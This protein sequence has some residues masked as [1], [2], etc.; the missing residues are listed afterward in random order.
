MLQLD[1]MIMHSYVLLV[2]A[3]LVL[4]ATS[5]HDRNT[6]LLTVRMDATGQAMI[7]LDATILLI[8]ISFYCALLHASVL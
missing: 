6:C 5:I 1:A 2:F 8:C 4:V 3:I 7:G